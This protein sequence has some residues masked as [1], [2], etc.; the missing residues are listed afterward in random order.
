MNFSYFKAETISLICFERE[1]KLF[2]LCTLRIR[3]IPYFFASN[4]ASF[5]HSK[6]LNIVVL[7][8]CFHHALQVLEHCH[9]EDFQSFT[10]ILSKHVFL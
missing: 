3:D 9:V 1:I 8:I 5:T 6:L 10:E 4:V 7:D 2:I